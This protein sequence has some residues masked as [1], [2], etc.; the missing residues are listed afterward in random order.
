MT[1]VNVD[2]WPIRESKVVFAEM[3]IFDSLVKFHKVGAF[4]KGLSTKIW[5]GLRNLFE[6]SDLCLF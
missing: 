6:I 3:V 2:C 1:V 5:R 4:G